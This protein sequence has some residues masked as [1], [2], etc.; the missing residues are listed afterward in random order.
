MFPSAPHRNR[1]HPLEKNK[2]ALTD[3]YL[4]MQAYKEPFLIAEVNMLNA[5]VAVVKGTR[6]S[7]T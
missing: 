3:I 1:N 7:K 6:I 4:L 2:T 5:T